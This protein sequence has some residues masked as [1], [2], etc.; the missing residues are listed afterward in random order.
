[1]KPAPA[2]DCAH[3]GRRIGQTA[4]HWLTE[5][6][7]VLCAR[8]LGRAAHADLYPDCEHR[9]HDVLDHEGSTG[10]RAGIAAHLG[11]WP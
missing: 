7:R 11:I 6:N 4:S 2:F 9:W 5:G 1:V 10:T 3:C 8:C